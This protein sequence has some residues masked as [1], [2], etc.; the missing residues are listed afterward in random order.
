MSKLV[1]APALTGLNF[2]SSLPE[3]RPPAKNA[4]PR[5]SSRFDKMDPIKLACTTRILHASRQACTVYITLLKRTQCDQSGDAGV[6]SQHSTALHCSASDNE[7][8]SARTTTASDQCHDAALQQVLAGDIQ[9]VHAH[10]VCAQSLH[11]KDQLRS[12][13]KTG[14]DQSSSR[15][16]NVTRHMLS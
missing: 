2:C 5:T 12:V 3:N 6:V 16:T 14:I 9:V 13:S 10:L 7:T 1:L 8:A 11:S 15:L 4:Q